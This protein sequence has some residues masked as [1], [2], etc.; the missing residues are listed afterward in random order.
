MDTAP[1]PGNSSTS[2]T[3]LAFVDDRDS[4]G[5]IRQCLGD[6]GVANAEI[7][8]GRID[9]AIAELSRRAVPRLLIVD[10][11]DSS[12]APAQLARLADVCEPSTGVVVIGDSN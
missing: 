6:L 3:V 7:V 2:A 11:A 10:I 5:V 9:R 8:H 1:L 4:E 12:D